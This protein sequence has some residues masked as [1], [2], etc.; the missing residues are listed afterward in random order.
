MNKIVEL[1]KS[2]KIF[3]QYESLNTYLYNTKMLELNIEI[4]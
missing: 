3:L 1:M 2:L 4:F